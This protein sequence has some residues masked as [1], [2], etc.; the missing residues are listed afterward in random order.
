MSSDAAAPPK[1]VKDLMTREVKT[2]GRNDRLS[3]ADEAMARGRLRHLPVI[4]DDGELAGI[5]SQRD[6][7]R[8]ALQRL[9]GYGEHAQ[10]RLFEQLAVKEVMTHEVVTI[11]PDAP[12]AEAARLMLDRRVGS[13]VV[14]RDGRIE[15]MLTEGDFVR[16]ALG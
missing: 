7:Y 13:L 2:L 8:G 14:V 6:M 9:M 15:G 11:A 16:A 3:V 10:D 1:L 5:V 12:L 4:D